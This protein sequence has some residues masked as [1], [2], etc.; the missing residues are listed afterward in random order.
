MTNV[1][2]NLLTGAVAVFIIV[3]LLGF[4]ALKTHASPATI[5]FETS[6]AATTTVTYLT[7]GGASTAFQFD[8]QTFG[9]NKVA[10]MI[11][12]SA[13]SVYLQVAASS[14]ATIYSV[15]PQWSNNGVDWYGFQQTLGTTATGVQQFATSTISYLWTP[16]TTSTTSAV[17]VL[18]NVPTYHARV[19]VSTTGAAGAVYIEADLRTDAQTP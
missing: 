4:F 9:S 19:L 10:S 18:P 13:T 2:N 17:F 5:Q 11:P 15:T 3:C 16:G 12:I 14:S 6:A 7:S 1:K 8:S